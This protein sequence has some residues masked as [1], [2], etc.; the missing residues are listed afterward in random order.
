MS[1]GDINTS[2]RS[3]FTHAAKCVYSWFIC[4]IVLRG[5]ARL[6]NVRKSCGI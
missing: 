6:K 4:E 1:A 3:E 5:T 2:Y